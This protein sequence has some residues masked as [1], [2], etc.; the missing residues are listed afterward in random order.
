MNQEADQVVNPVVETPA[1]P[2]LDTVLE[3]FGD[4][5][6]VII[7]GETPVVADPA[8]TM[9]TEPTGELHT[10]VVDGTEQQ[11]SLDDMKRDYSFRKH[12][13]QRAAELNRQQ[14]EVEA[15]RRML[16]YAG[17]DPRQAQP[18]QPQQPIP[19][20]QFQQGAEQIEY[21]TPVEEMLHRELQAMKQQVG[22]INE[23]S[24][25]QR[26]NTVIRDTQKTWDDFRSTHNDLD[27]TALA[28][29]LEVIN[30]NELPLTSETLDLVHKSFTDE[31]AIAERAVTEY[32]DKLR[33]NNEAVLEPSTESGKHAPPNVR[34]MA[35]DDIVKLASQETWEEEY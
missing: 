31:A 16:E 28:A 2:D 18:Q 11:V 23:Q 35:E 12:N 25:N 14:E 4:E 13:E 21:A 9:P 29:R 19:Q 15:T 30:K 22:A 20:Q 6:E 1:E 10:V 26:L 33:K 7:E 32:Q 24:R 17:Y 8:E 3:G 27:E 5:D 34:D